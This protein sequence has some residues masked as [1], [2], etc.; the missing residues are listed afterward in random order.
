MS[1]LSEEQFAKR[2]ACRHQHQ[3]S[4]PVPGMVA[5]SGQLQLLVHEGCLLFRAAHVKDTAAAFKVKT[6]GIQCRRQGTLKAVLSGCKRMT[7]GGTRVGLGAYNGGAHLN[8][9]IG[10]NPGS[11]AR[12][13]RRAWHDSPLPSHQCWTDSPETAIH[14]PSR[15]L[16][17]KDSV[18]AMW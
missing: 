7:A 6:K 4:N 18:D 17:I 16:R 13:A 8:G 5:E 2:K 10:A 12:M 14:L 9:G 11:G 15:C 3:G 1:T